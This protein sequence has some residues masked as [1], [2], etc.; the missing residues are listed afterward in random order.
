M[1]EDILEV[2]PFPQPQQPIECMILPLQTLFAHQRYPMDTPQRLHSFMIALFTKGRGQHFVDFQSHAYREQTL[3]FVA[4]NQVHQWEIRPENEALVLA[5]SKEFLYKNAQDW[6][7]VTRYRI[8][9][10]ALRS[11]TLALD[12]VAYRRFLTLFEELKTE[13]DQPGQDTFKD[14]IYRNLLRTILLLAERLKHDET[15][16]TATLHYQDFTRFRDQVESD[17]SHTRNVQDYA[18]KLGYSPKKLNQLTQTTLNQNA[19]RFIDERVVLEIKRL[20]IHTNLSIKEIADRTGFD[21]PTN[22]VKFFKRY[23]EQTPLAFRE[24]IVAWSA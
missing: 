6:E 13:F 19:K 21:E 1:P 14:D 4:E 18:L 24:K 15:P 10:Y 8:F 22:L 23:T 2:R 11:P 7:V 16:A 12:A 17:Y 20:L 9:D 5:F 3:L